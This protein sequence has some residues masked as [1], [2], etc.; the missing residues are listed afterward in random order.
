MKLSF[1]SID[2]YSTTICRIVKVMCFSRVSFWDLRFVVHSKSL[3]IGIIITHYI[4]LHTVCRCSEGGN[5]RSV[6][7]LPK[8]LYVHAVR[9]QVSKNANKQAGRRDKRVGR[10]IGLAKY[11]TVF[12]M[13]ME[14]IIYRNAHKMLHLFGLIFMVTVFSVQ[15]VAIKK[16]IC[17]PS[18]IQR[19]EYA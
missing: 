16:F 15:I 14:M 11:G 4:W 12:S 9:L 19:T 7:Q 10:F 17:T 13:Q 2:D 8:N 18:G 6:Y 5:I 1:S 3:H